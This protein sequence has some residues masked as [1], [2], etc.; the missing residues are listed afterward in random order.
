MKELIERWRGEMPLFWKKV[1]R[2]WLAISAIAAVIVLTPAEKMQLITQV[3]PEHLQHY[4][5][6]ISQYALAIGVISWFQTQLT[7]K[8]KENVKD[9]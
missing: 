1:Q 7:V 3:L 8:D 9:K 6:K 2:M 5:E 4:V